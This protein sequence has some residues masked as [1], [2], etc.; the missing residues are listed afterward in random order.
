[1]ASIFNLQSPLSNDMSHA[2]QMDQKTLEIK[3]KINVLQLTT[4]ERSKDN[5]R[6]HT[7]STN[8]LGV[9]TNMYVCML[10]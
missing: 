3:V 6:V 1:M 4:V 10:N 5:L 2:Q 7:Y 9:D 8:T